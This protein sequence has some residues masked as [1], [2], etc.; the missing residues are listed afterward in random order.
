MS[1]LKKDFYDIDEVVKKIGTDI[2]NRDN[3]YAS[4]SPNASELRHKGNVTELLLHLLSSILV[5]EGGKNNSTAL[6]LINSI[7]QDII[8]ILL[9][10]RK[11]AKVHVA[12]GL[13]LKRK[14]GSKDVLTWLNR[15][16][17]CI[18]YD[19][20]NRIDTCLAQIK[21]KYNENKRF[22]PSNI[23]PSSFVT[24]LADNGDHNLYMVKV[25]IAPI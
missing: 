10:N 7:G 22:I 23:N 25:S 6:T 12:L 14:T 2:E 8:Y 4:W 18:S 17:C 13:C 16:G 3:T 19:K 21:S 1:H 24:F 15:L 11:K 20:V 9:R 5:K